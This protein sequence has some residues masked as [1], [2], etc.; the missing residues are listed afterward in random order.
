[1]GFFCSGN[2]QTEKA[3]FLPI[4]RASSVQNK[5]FSKSKLET[6]FGMACINVWQ[7]LR[8]TLT[9]QIILDICRYFYVTAIHIHEQFS[10]HVCRNNDSPVIWGP[11]KQPW[12]S[13]SHL[14]SISQLSISATPLAVNEDGLCITFLKRE[15]WQDAIDISMSFRGRWAIQ[16][17]LPWILILDSSTPFASLS[18]FA[19]ELDFFK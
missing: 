19:P 10:N 17:L 16:M 1:M 3:S 5:R 13:Q 6:I 18:P 9:L 4:S 15:S 7:I 14:E 2:P 11:D 12:A 8:F